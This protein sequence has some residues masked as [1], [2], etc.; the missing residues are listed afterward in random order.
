[1]KKLSSI[2]IVFLFIAGCNTN[3]NASEKQNNNKNVAQVKNS[4]IEENNKQSSQQ[5]A[6]RLVDLAVQ[7]PH[8]NDATAAVLGDY[9][10]VGI[11]VD[12]NVERSEVG[13][14][15]YAVGE[16]LKNDPYG[17]DA[18]IVADPDMNA[19]IREV[20]QDIQNG[21]PV[22]GILNELSDI[23]GR[24]IPDVPGDALK[25]T[26]TRATEEKKQGIDSE[27]D[28]KTLEREQDR[29]SSDQND[30]E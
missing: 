20:S 7:V 13:T 15:K 16:A 1:M 19:R 10:V 22:R 27:K 2:A 4:T 3:D 8:V 6:R 17:A 9:A 24:I 29:Q 25:P 5:I 11:D 14:I 12:A 18:A 21:Q 28:K 26:P 30:Q 23:T